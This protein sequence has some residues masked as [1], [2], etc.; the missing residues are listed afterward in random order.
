MSPFP[1]LGKKSAGDVTLT[2]AAQGTTPEPVAH[3]APPR[4][5]RFARLRA[6]RA[7]RARLAPRLAP[8][9]R[10]VRRVL[11]PI[12]RVVGVLLLIA[13][14]TSLIGL[15]RSRAV[16]VPVAPPPRLVVNDV[17]KLNP[18][19]VAAIER[20]TTTEEVAAAVR[21]HP[22]P[23]AIGGGRFSMGG[24]T[25]TPGGVQ[26]DLRALR[27]VVS[28]APRERVI[29]VRAGTT[30]REV[31]QA[32]DSA[33]LAVKVMQTYNSF[34]VGGT[35]SVNAHGRYIG[36]GPAIGAVRAIRLVLAD[37]SIVTASRTEN[38][39]LFF[40]AIGGYG[41]IGVITEATLDLATNV[42][43]RRDDSTMAIAAYRA[44]FERAIQADRHVVFHNADIYPP[45]YDRVHAVTYRETDAPLTV[46]ERIHPAD[47]SSGLHRFVYG[48]ISGTQAGPWV[49][50]HAIDPLIFGGNPVTWRNYEASYDVSEL[51]PASR[52]KST[53]VLQEYFVPVDSLDV[54]VARM[55]GV[56]RDYHVNAVNVSIR[57][58]EPD[59]G[60]L[61]AWAPDETY[62]FVLYYRQGTDAASRH[63]VGRWTRAMAD[64]A[65]AS[66]G[67]W[68]LPYQP[69]A[70]RAQ[71]LRAYPRSA[72]YFAL[73][74]RVDPQGRFTNTLWDVYAPGAD[75]AASTVSAA[76]MPAY[77]P[78]EVRAALDTMTGYQR[79]E[80]AA[81]LTH[82]EWD[83]VYTSDAYAAWLAAGRKPSAF[84][85]TATVGTF[86]RSYWAT[87]RD[88]RRRFD[89][90]LGLHVMLGVIGTSTA[91]EYGLKAAY[92]NT[93]G[94]L[95]ELAMPAG[96]TAEDRYAA[97]V[98]TDYGTLIHDRGWYEFCFSCA[99]GDLWRDV[100]LGGPGLPRK[101]ERRFVL[102]AEYAIKAVYATLIGL[103]TS[104]GYDPDRKERDLLVAGWSDSLAGEPALRAVRVRARLDRGYSLVT[105][106]R[107]DAYGAAL[108]ALGRH[109][110]AVRL[111]EASGCEVITLVG[112]VP[113]G[114]AAPAQSTPVLAYADPVAPAR[115]RVLLR[116]PVRDVLDVLASMQGQP[117]VHVEH[118]YDY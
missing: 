46:T 52:E 17:T 88:A 65:I 24:Q 11:R 23:I 102:S 78:G 39:D 30:W 87:Y 118:V 38:P 8:V 113:A 92:E 110:S 37:G 75:G 31:Q 43:V 66:G 62:A 40:G 104:A 68:Y 116:T 69:H 93:I 117:G 59:Q 34:T 101:I 64:A 36:N 42:K 16:A 109:A 45:A 22:G 79:E 100:P 1:S 91:L 77:V 49:R 98:A 7:L 73:K 33:G 6:L 76:R 44:Y 12:A 80:S 50:E 114:W 9:W 19:A 21:A 18:I 57:H 25:A 55:G 27:G 58:A 41:G 63:A 56:L 48:V 2:P 29:T 32:I 61:L 67:R 71:F 60:S 47:Q 103:G 86:W 53:F 115:T 96:G 99:L 28:F 105:V 108:L 3:A 20:P 26:L 35:L 83:L 85:Y 51:E 112:T 97:R 70:T 111:A 54:F 5:R 72:E 10:P 95:S 106:P 14:L 90:P 15:A 4:R 13:L 84:P 94:R 74:R 89:V 82:P 81:L 107:Y